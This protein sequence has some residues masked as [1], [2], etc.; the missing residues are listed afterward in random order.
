MV[1][2]VM[3]GSNKSFP[4]TNSPGTFWPL[5][6]HQRQTAYAPVAATRPPATTGRLR[7]RFGDY[8]PV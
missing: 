2:A 6:R 8:N 3:C 7:T 5:R 1:S 4:G